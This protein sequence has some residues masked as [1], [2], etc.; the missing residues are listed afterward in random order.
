MD[1]KDESY[2][3][4]YNSKQQSEVEKIK[5]KYVKKPETKI[6]QMRR[7][8]KNVESPGTLVAIC[9]GVLGT[10]IFGAGMSASMVI[11]DYLLGI[12]LCILGFLIL[13]S[14]LPLYRWITE[15][16]RKKIAP[17]IMRLAQ[18]IADEANQSKGKPDENQEGRLLS[19]ESKD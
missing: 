9:A 5:E 4:T 13:G 12:P 1:K 18:E 15:R 3:Y 8:D 7:L 2:K 16:K 19:R 6:E 17:T 10:L 14:A 11:Q